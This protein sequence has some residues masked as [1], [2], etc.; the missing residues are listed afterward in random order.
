MIKEGLTIISANIL[1]LSRELSLP[2]QNVFCVVFLALCC[3][4]LEFFTLKSSKIFTARRFQ[5]ETNFEHKRSSSC[6][7]I[8]FD[9]CKFMSF[10]AA[11]KLVLLISLKVQYLLPVCQILWNLSKGN[12][13]K[14]TQYFVFIFTS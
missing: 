9:F 13:T 5:Q 11:E 3:D 7:G 2:K 10:T 6:K 12:A 4:F 1:G 8:F 14:F